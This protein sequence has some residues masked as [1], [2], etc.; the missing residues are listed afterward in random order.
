L[1]SIAYFDIFRYPLTQTEVC[2]FLQTPRSNEAV[3][4][5]LQQLT[6]ESLL[7]KFDDYYSLQNDYSLV[8]RRRRGNLQARSMLRT[9]EKIAAFISAFPFVRGVAV[10]GSLSKNF[11]DKDSDI[12]FFIIT[13]RNRLWIA[14]TFLHLFK[15]FT[16]LV[17]RQ[18]WYCMNY[19]VDEDALQIREKNIFT[20]TEV[21]TLLPL[22]GI[23]AFR[24]F[25]EANGWQ[26]RFLPNHSM[27]ISYVK[28]VKKPGI[29][30][31]TEF[32]FH[33][34]F[35]N[36]LDVL[37]QKL[38]ARRWRLKTKKRLLNK[39]GIVMGMDC[40]RHYAKPDPA[41]FQKQF[42]EVY[43]SK[44]QQLRS[45]HQGEVKSIY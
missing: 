6:S 40:S 22:R 37:L 11:A 35:G 31:I 8:V 26:R 28:G 20:A 23:S 19:F 42:M 30:A 13:A 7:F 10:S 45:K 33:N 18:D 38:T 39:R 21:A 43:A 34:P 3:T 44:M 16:F 14:R 15:K 27:R 9:A 36:L 5:A 41:N 25:F 1:A 24:D 12:D 29:K 17:N 32:F 2:Q 4:I